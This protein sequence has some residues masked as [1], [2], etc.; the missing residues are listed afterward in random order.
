MTQL[1]KTDEIWG[2][3]PKKED[4]SAGANYAAI[5]L[6]WTFNRMMLNTRSAGQQS[7]ALNIAKG[8]I[9]QEVLRRALAARGISAE[10]QRK[11]YRDEDMFDFHVLINGTVTKL[12]VKTLNYYSDYAD[13]GRAPFSPK[14]VIANAGYPGPDWRRF[15]PMLVPHTQ[16]N[17][18]KEAYCFAIASSID[19]RRN[20]HTNRMGYAL[21]AFPYGKPMGFMSSRQ[22]CINRE[23]ADNGFYIECSYTTENL[24]NGAEMTL[25]VLGEWAGTFKKVEV[26]LKRNRAVSG[27]GPFSCVSSFQIGRADYDRLF[28]QIKVSVCRND[29]TE[30]V[31]NSARLNINVAPKESL[32]FTREDFCNLILPSDYTIYFIGWVTKEDFL[33]K[34]RNYT[35]WVWPLDRINKYENQPWSQITEKDRTSIE[36]AGFG[37]C[38]QEKTRL[39]KAGWMKTHGGGG[40]ACCYV[41]PNIGRHGGVK[42]TNLYIL[43]QDLHIMEELGV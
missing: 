17:Q 43:P 35:G 11:S 22:L 19:F 9:G 14:F 30:P 37:D 31:R 13:V 34:C 27:I 33:Q 24:F 5:T 23:R 16:I 39:M 10:V 3:T 38:I 8:I 20:V 4:L 25:T 42:E 29:F 28:G 32:V 18:D 26:P 41:Y 15:F 1:S 36:R 12:D 7:R 6:P 2:L 40:G 21:T